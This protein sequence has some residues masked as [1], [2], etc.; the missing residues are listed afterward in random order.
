MDKGNKVDKETLKI[1]LS[2][3]RVFEH[4]GSFLYSLLLWP[5]PSFFHDYHRTV[6]IARYIFLIFYKCEK[7]F[8]HSLFC[9]NV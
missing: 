8:Y 4:K 5:M 1:Q 6:V 3:F 2:L 9:K 7:M